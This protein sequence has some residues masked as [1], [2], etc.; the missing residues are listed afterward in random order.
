MMPILAAPEAAESFLYDGGH[1]VEENPIPTSMTIQLFHLGLHIAE[2]TANHPL[3]FVRRP[4]DIVVTPANYRG[5]VRALNGGGSPTLVV[6]DVIRLLNRTEI[7]LNYLVLARQ[8]SEK[9]HLI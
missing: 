3:D 1:M 7:L 4:Q 9:L 2:V 8:Q 5:P 6:P